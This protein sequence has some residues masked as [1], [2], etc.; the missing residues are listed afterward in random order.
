[1]AIQQNQVVRVTRWT[2]GQHPTMSTIT[3]MMKAQGLRPYMWTNTPNHRY[4][5]RSHGYDKVLC[6]VEGALELVLPDSNQRVRLRPGDRADIPAGTRHGAIV[7]SNG[8]TC[9]EASIARR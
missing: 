5:V 8:V 4:A 2:G 6:V 1:M 9:V 3:R 7:G